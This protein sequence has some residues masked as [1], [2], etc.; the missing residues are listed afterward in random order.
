MP[1]LKLPD[2]H[3]NEAA[4][5]L[6]AVMFDPAGRHEDHLRFVDAVRNQAHQNVLRTNEQAQNNP[7][8]LPLA[9]G[10]ALGPRLEDESP[11][12][13][14]FLWTR[15]GLLR[16]DLAVR[17]FL[18][19]LAYAEHDPIHAS[20]ENAY[21]MW[22]RAA[23]KTHLPDS[24]RANM[25]KIFDDYHSV[26]HFWAASLMAQCVWQAAKEF[27][28]SRLA[29]F[30]GFAERLRLLGEAV[31]LDGRSLLDPALTWKVSERFVLPQWNI[32]IPTPSALEAETLR[33]PDLSKTV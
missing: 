1:Y 25:V 11:R 6:Q 21:K 16:G 28:G 18:I 24:S 32:A 14:R 12:I 13:S 31:S 8:A 7:K 10:V 22:R 15:G 19:V 20:K 30:L 17:L 9:M 27:G 23:V 26:I 29:D 4:A 3:H 33:W 5:Y 2:L